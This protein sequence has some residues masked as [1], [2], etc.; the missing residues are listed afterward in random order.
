MGN[1]RVKEEMRRREEPKENTIQV[2]LFD[3]SGTMKKQ[4]YQNRNLK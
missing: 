2:R 4:F 1:M 3:G